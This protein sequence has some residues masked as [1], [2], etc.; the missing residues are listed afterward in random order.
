MTNMTNEQKNIS[1]LIREFEET[2]VGDNSRYGIGYEAWKE[3]KP[4]LQIGISR[5]IEG[6]VE[7]FEEI[8]KEWEAHEEA[9]TCSYCDSP[10]GHTNLNNWLRQALTD[11]YQAGV[12]AE[13]V[14][15]CM[16][17]W[18]K[19]EPAWVIVVIKNNESIFEREVTQSE[20]SVAYQRSQN[21]YAS[22]V[23]TTGEAQIG[24]EYIYYQSL[25]PTP[26]NE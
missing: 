10:K 2:F 23:I 6:K 8:Q 20:L 21:R 12:E 9:N 11:T 17:H 24:A 15:V 16:P 22:S 13:R 18:K 3:M 26:S 25:T 14:C 5:V 4:W 1:S 7:E 19:N